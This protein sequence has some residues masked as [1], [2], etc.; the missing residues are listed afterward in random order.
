M[1][2]L[3]SLKD[4]IKWLH[5][6]DSRHLESR[7]VLE[8]FKGQTAWEGTVAVFQLIGHPKAQECYAWAIPARKPPPIAVPSIGNDEVRFVAVLGIPPVVSPETAVKA[9]LVTKVRIRKSP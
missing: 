5:G 3:A 6:C 7:R 1:D 2:Y 9:Y 8:T 4:A